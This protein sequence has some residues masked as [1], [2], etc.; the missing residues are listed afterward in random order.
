MRDSDSLLLIHCQ[1]TFDSY[2]KLIIFLKSISLHWIL[3]FSLFTA[4]CSQA[5]PL[6]LPIHTYI[7][8]HK[9]VWNFSN[10]YH[11]CL[12]ITYD[13]PTK[14]KINSE[15]E[16]TGKYYGDL[17]GMCQVLSVY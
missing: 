10:T 12:S 15:V 13:I 7:N 8:T 1:V 17:K 3:I 16:I 9:N 6:D 4:L 5:Y 2:S 14:I 11:H